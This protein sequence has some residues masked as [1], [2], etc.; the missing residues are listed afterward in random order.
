MVE[1]PKIPANIGRPSRTDIIIGG[2]IALGVIAL[3]STQWMP[4]LSTGVR[5]AAK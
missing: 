5:E 4:A 1:P 3:L 2:A